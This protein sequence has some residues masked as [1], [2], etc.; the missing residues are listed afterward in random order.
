MNLE[1]IQYKQNYM[2]KNAFLTFGTDATLPFL[3]L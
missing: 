3:G 2:F 1:K